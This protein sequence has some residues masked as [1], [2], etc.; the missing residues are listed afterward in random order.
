MLYVFVGNLT[1]FP[2]VFYELWK[3]VNIRWSCHNELVVY[4]MQAVSRSTKE[5]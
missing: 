4:R 2:A 3:L 5:G 1:L